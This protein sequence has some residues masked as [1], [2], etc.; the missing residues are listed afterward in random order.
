V[1]SGVVAVPNTAETAE[2]RVLIDSFVDKVVV[3]MSKHRP[4]KLKI[5]ATTGGQ[6]KFLLK[7]H[8]DLRQDQRVLQFFDLINSIVS[9]SMPKI[10]VAAVTPLSPC[11]GMIRWLRKCATMHQLIQRYRENDKSRRLGEENDAVVTA[12]F[13]EAKDHPRPLLDLLD[14]L[15]PI[16]R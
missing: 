3:K 10:I 12:T 16:Q 5:R 7:G 4:S 2:E 6:F 11:A 13:G 8:E 1:P 14:F 9:S 15:R